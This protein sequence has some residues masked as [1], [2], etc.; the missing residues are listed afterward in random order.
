MKKL[1]LFFFILNFYR[2]SLSQYSFS[3]DTISTPKGNLLI[4]FI[5]HGTLMLEFN[6]MIIHIDPWS[7]LTNYKVL[8][9]ADLILITHH[10]PDH[11]DT[12][13]IV[14]ISK[15]KTQMILTQSVFDLLKHGIVMH[16]GDTK[17]LIGINIKAVPAYNISRG[18]VKF[19]PKDRDNGYILTIGN[20]IIYIAGDTENISEM[21]TFGK[22]DIA[23][24]PMNQPYTMIPEQ[25]IDAARKINPKILYPYHFGETDTSNLRKLLFDS[26]I[27]LRIRLMK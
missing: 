13:A 11:F 5:G 21:S 12:N 7:N 15:P 22:I 17:T 10:H 3:S 6:K 19:H 20:K 24:L 4:Y 18:H 1:L 27:D 9:K 8:P 2:V 26:K 14:Q 23:F 16:N 25:F